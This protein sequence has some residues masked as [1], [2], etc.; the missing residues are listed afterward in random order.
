M[1]IFEQA[2]Q[3]VERMHSICSRPRLPFTLEPG[4]P[5]FLESK[6]GGTPYLPHEMDW[7]L[8]SQGRPLAL[9]AQIDCAELKGLAGFPDAGLLQFFVGQDDVYGMDFDDQIEPK[10]FRAIYHEKVDPSVTVREAAS[11]RPSSPEDGDLPLMKDAPARICFGQ[12]EEQGI[13][14]ADYA[15]DPL[16]VRVWNE[17]FPDE[18]IQAMWDVM[19]KMDE[20]DVERLLN[21]EN[22]EDFEGPE[23]PW[24]QLGGYPFFTQSD[25][26]GEKPEYEGFDTLLFQLD[27]DSRDRRDL[28]LWGD[29]GVGNFFIRREDLARRDFS[30]VLYNW[31]CC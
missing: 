27:S 13:T 2:R 23:V 28:V 29:C 10:G 21:P 22:A 7:P 31:D 18:P 30:K 1:A 26:R 17:L 9:L 11:K 25:P 19:E 14:G 8:D 4:E 12:V 5:G 6:V 3:T 20:D 16:F 24:H 15:F